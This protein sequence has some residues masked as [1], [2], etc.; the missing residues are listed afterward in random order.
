M[1]CGPSE[2]RPAVNVKDLVYFEDLIP[3][4]KLLTIFILI[5]CI[6]IFSVY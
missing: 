6:I 2:L 4:N 5:T 1:K 3:P